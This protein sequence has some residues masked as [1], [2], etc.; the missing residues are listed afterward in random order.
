MYI[1]NY[2]TYSS[3]DYQ[4]YIHNDS[5]VM[6]AFS[7][8]PDSSQNVVVVQYTSDNNQA[9]VIPKNT[10]T[11]ESVIARTKNEHRD[12][13]LYTIPFN[14]PS[15]LSSVYDKLFG[16]QNC[17]ISNFRESENQPI[18]PYLFRRTSGGIIYS[19]IPPKNV[20]LCPILFT[21][22]RRKCIQGSRIDYREVEVPHLVHVLSTYDTVLTQSKN[23]TAFPTSTFYFDIHFWELIKYTE[24][25]SF[26]TTVGTGFGEFLV[27]EIHTE[28]Q[29]II[30][31]LPSENRHFLV[32]SRRLLP[33]RDISRLCEYAHPGSSI[34]EILFRGKD[35]SLPKEFDELY[36]D[37]MGI[38]EFIAKYDNEAHGHPSTDMDSI[39]IYELYRLAKANSGVKAT[40]L[41]NDRRYNAPVLCRKSATFHHVTYSR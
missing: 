4:M 28:E 25:Y 31:A 37:A 16:A 41:E 6:L 30:F 14:I 23:V 33:L 27:D 38:T 2:G 34:Y 3:E 35:T 5:I 26:I 29:H 39:D 8:Q 17:F 36:F 22:P 18:I 19:P 10:M 15:L 20:P 12:A 32:Q 24:A 7:A 21:F 11:L 13:Y 1:E 9:L 40:K